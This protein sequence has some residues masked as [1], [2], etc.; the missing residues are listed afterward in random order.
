MAEEWDQILAAIGEEFWRLAPS[1]IVTSA[2]RDITFLVTWQDLMAA[3][4][5]GIFPLTEVT[6]DVD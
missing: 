6:I 4:E 1:W 5:R 3:V 2:H